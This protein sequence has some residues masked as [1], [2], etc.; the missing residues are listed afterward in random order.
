MD[1]QAAG[2]DAAGIPPAGSEA[3]PGG[4]SFEAAPGFGNGDGTALVYHHQFHPNCEECRRQ[5]YI[6]LHQAQFLAP[7]QVWESM[8]PS[9]QFYELRRL[10]MPE[11]EFFQSLSDFEP[12]LAQ[13]QEH[14]HQQEYQQQQPF[15]PLLPMAEEQQPVIGMQNIP[16]EVIEPLLFQQGATG[17]A[18]VPTTFQPAASEPMT[19]Q[20]GV[21]GPA[22]AE[23]TMYMPAFVPSGVEASIY[24]PAEFNFNTLPHG[25]VQQPIQGE[26]WAM[27]HDGSL[28]EPT[29]EDGFRY[30]APGEERN[31]FSSTVPQ[32]NEA[33]T[34]MVGM[35]N[36]VQYEP[37]VPSQAPVRAP[38]RLLPSNGQREL[39]V[40]RQPEGRARR[41]PLVQLSS[42]ESLERAEK[43]LFLI[44]SRR[45]NI[46]Y[47]DIKRLGNFAEA[48]S[49]L[50]GR[51]RTLTKDKK[52]RV[53]DPKWTDIDIHL[54]K[55]AVRVLG[56][57]L[58]PD[59]AK[60][61]WMAVSRYISN[62]GGS[63]DFGFSTCHRRWLQLEADGQLEDTGYDDSW[64]D[65][66]E[67]AET[68]ADVEEERSDHDEEQDSI[69]AD[70]HDED[71]QESEEE[72][73]NPRQMTEEDQDESDSESSSDSDDDEDAG[74]PIK[75]EI[76]T[77]EE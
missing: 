38:R 45:Q 58:H 31:V 64:A 63:Y 6:R 39:P 26:P 44:E 55:E 68:L 23:P 16:D 53:R 28:F 74:V 49:T 11:D 29:P 69:M 30:E 72:K 40:H 22:M 70:E 41:M 75:V 2:S 34:N 13:F 12:Y 76:K 17:E 50:R 37:P 5:A 56:H 19:V 8:D 62:H 48:E 7:P 43:D 77:E 47:K 57:G 1:N 67:D 73:K 42:E 51:Y 65:E 32:M 60:L 46:S 27:T 33:T 66:D 18:F 24:E 36:P 10:T 35:Q 20:P 52:N 9:A 14:Q 25:P 59:R 54:L 21:Y 15:V 71:D 61:S 4:Q 3:F